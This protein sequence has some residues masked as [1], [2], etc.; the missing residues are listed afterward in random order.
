M[1]VGIQGAFQN[2]VVIGI[3]AI[4]HG[5]LWRHRMSQR[6]EI[7]G[8]ISDALLRPRNFSTRMPSTSALI[9]SEIETSNAPASAV[10][11]TV[12]GF[13]HLGWCLR[14]R[15][16]WMALTTSC[17]VRTPAVAADLRP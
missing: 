15:A 17:S 2:A 6:P 16:A 11:I 1:T 3:D 12:R 10:S 14:M 5:L 13:N 7:V 9:G 8:R 4:G